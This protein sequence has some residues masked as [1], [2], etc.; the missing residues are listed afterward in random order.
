MRFFY[1]GTPHVA[2]MTVNAAIFLNKNKNKIFK[3]KKSKKWRVPL[4]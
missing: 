3:I 4:H 2:F 1:N